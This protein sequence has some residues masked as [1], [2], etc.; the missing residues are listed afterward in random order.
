MHEAPCSSQDKASNLKPV[1]ALTGFS[2][3]NIV[4]GTYKIIHHRKYIIEDEFEHVV[5]PMSETPGLQ[6]GIEK[7]QDVVHLENGTEV[8]RTTT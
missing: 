1:N 2:S 4:K 6:Q 7:G 8:C 3:K 5:I